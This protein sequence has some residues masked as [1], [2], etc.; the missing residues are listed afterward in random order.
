MRAGS[1]RH[2]VRVEQYTETQDTA[3]Q[4]IKGYTTFAT[5]HASI[6]NITGQELFRVQ[7]VFPAATARIKMRYLRGLDS[8]M[9]IVHGE[10][11]YNILDVDDVEERHIEHVCLC[12]TGFVAVEG[13]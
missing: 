10:T 8:R 2:L 4:P 3:G 11:Y 12:Q 7:E 1:L 5:V 6:D 13:V 9:R